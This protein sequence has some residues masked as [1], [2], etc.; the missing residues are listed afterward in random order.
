MRHDLLAL[1]GVGPLAVF[2]AALYAREGLKTAAKRFGQVLLVSVAVLAAVGG[3]EKLLLRSLDIGVDSIAGR[4]GSGWL[5]AGAAPRLDEPGLKALEDDICNCVTAVPRP[6]PYVA[7]VIRS[8]G[9]VYEEVQQLLEQQNP[10]YRI[11]NR[12]Q[13]N[14]LTDS[15]LNDMVGC[16]VR[17]RPG[18]FLRQGLERVLG[19]AG[20]GLDQEYSVTASR[21]FVSVAD[22]YPVTVGLINGS[23]LS[24]DAREYDA[25]AASRLFFLGALP[26]PWLGLAAMLGVTAGLVALRSRPGVAVLGPAL[27]AVGLAHVVLMGLLA[28]AVARYAYVF[29]LLGC[30]ALALTAAALLERPYGPADPPSA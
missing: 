29:G 17:N 30:I 5:N 7:A 15:L 10:M 4:V 13:L 9:E 11:L 18:R 22:R 28:G 3:A 16:Y 8:R 20:I 27:L 24:A 21:G 12:R 2:C 25:I 6:Q 23:F 14:D 19:F 1:L 26:L